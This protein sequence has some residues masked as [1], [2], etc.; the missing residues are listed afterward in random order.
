MQDNL[1]QFKVNDFGQGAGRETKN[2]I[3]SKD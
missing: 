3:S 2:E 1:S